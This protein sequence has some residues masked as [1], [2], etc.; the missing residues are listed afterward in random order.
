MLDEEAKQAGKRIGLH[1][2]VDT[3][4]QNQFNR[5][6]KIR[7]LCSEL[8]TYSHIDLEGIFTILLQLMRKTEPL[9]ITS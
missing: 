9:L 5:P 7:E 2:K 1:V 8:K 6:G 3:G 4:M